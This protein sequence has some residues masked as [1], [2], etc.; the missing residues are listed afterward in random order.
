MVPSDFTAV[1]LA[2]ALLRERY[3]RWKCAQ[4]AVSKF[5][6]V[7]SFS[8]I[9]LRLYRGWRI[10]KF[11]SEGEFLR[12]SSFSFKGLFFYQKDYIEAKFEVVLQIFLFEIVGGPFLF[13]S[14]NV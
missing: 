2:R 12:A 13:K 3:C 8:L 9:N 10:S 1:P 4:A 11:S 5:C 14:Y 7:S 6:S